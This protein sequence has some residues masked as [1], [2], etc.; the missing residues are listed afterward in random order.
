MSNKLNRYRSGDYKV[1]KDSYSGWWTVTDARYGTLVMIA[2]DEQGARDYV[3][4][5]GWRVVD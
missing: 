5:R 2:A 3:T 1:S 4:E